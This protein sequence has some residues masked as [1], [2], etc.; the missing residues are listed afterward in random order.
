MP[1][2]IYSNMLSRASRSVA[3]GILVVGLLLIGFGMLIIALPELFAFLAAAVFFLAGAGCAIA[4][5]KIFWMQRRLD[6]F[7]SHEDPDAHRINVRIHTGDR[8]EP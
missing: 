8:D 4:A 1:F 2:H 5:I 3:S 6:R 7:A